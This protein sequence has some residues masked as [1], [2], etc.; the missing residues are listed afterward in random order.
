MSRTENVLNGAVVLRTLVGILNQQANAGPG[1]HALEYAGED[2]HLVRLAALGGIARGSRTTAIEIVLE[3]GFGK[4]N[5]WR[6]AVNDAAQ[7]Q[8]M[9]FAERRFCRY[10]CV[11]F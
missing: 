5:A 1:G 8:A 2:L 6:H 7:R 4:R 9:R 10:V 3:I 11:L